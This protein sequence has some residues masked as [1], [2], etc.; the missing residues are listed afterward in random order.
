MRPKQCLLHSTQESLTVPSSK[1]PFQAKRRALQFTATCGW[2][3]HCGTN[4]WDCKSL[5]VL[6]TKH[7]ALDQSSGCQSDRYKASICTAAA[8]ASLTWDVITWPRHLCQPLS[9]LL[10]GSLP[11]C[12]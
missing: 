11:V 2:N 1:L 9:E 10:V 3:T 4:P 8:H 5:K 6:H 7:N 12:I